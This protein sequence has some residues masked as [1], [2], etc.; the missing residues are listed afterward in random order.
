MADEN[1]T[2]DEALKSDFVKLVEG[3]QKTIFIK[4]WTL[5]KVF[6]FDKECVEFA[7]KVTEED[8]EEV[9]KIYTTVSKPL[10]YT[11]GPILKDLN[12]EEGVK[13]SIIKVGDKKNVKYS[14]KVVKK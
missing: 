1:I 2:W 12:P 13:I 10:Q 11:L 14:M 8:G 5:K 6:K 9:N 4:D 3:E 7:T